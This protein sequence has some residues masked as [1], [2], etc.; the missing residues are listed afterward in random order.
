MPFHF[1]SSSFISFSNV[2]QFS[3]CRCYTSFVN[4]ILKCVTHIDAINF[5]ILATYSE[6]L[7]SPFVTPNSFQCFLCK[8]LSSE[9]R[10]GFTSSFPMP[11]N[12]FSF[13][14]LVYNLVNL[15]SCFVENIPHQGESGPRGQLRKDCTFYQSIGRVT[16]WLKICLLSPLTFLPSMSHIGHLGDLFLTSTNQQQ[17]QFSLLNSQ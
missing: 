14:C 8:I 4:F 7:L 9:N 3:V 12:S 2:L 6:T 16:K 1:F 17:S 13:S 10:D 15:S 5:Y 11:F